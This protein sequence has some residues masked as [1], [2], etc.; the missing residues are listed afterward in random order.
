MH[1]AP[2]CKSWSNPRIINHPRDA[3]I[4]L[5]GIN[6]RLDTAW[7]LSICSTTPI[8]LLD[9]ASFL[10]VLTVL[11]I[12]GSQSSRNLW[13]TRHQAT[14]WLL[15]CVA[16]QAFPQ[17]PFNPWHHQATSHSLFQTQPLPCEAVDQWRVGCIRR[18]F[19]SIKE[20]GLMSF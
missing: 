17:V 9:P 15:V 1:W 20:G 2:A 12:R 10:C 4:I 13:S 5:L 16:C 8:I 11:S 18:W 3:S 7:H 19:L 14:G 6:H